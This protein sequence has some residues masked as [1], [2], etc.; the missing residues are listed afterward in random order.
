MPLKIKNIGKNAQKTRKVGQNN[1]TVQQS[2]RNSRR[3][4]RWDSDSMYLQE[5]EK[6]ALFRAIKSPRDKAIFRLAYQRGL[7]A[8]EISLLQ[9]ADYNDKRGILYVHRL[10]GSD[11][12]EYR[13]F[14]QEVTALRA[15][16]KIRGTK[17]GP[18]FPSQMGPR[19]GSRGIT[20][21]RLDQLI[22]KYAEIAGIREAKAH[23]HAL[24]HSCG[25]HL[26][27]LG[28]STHMIQNH[29]GHVNS[30]NC[31]IYLHVTPKMR[32]AAWERLKDWK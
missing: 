2:K 28:E 13:L 7:R 8:S 27:E 30:Q 24:R 25:T 31:D 17:P 29:L 20:R 18:L 9:M 22:K 6:E 4:R 14:P 32:D 16:L 12:R 1:Q 11:S 23:M 26:A 19:I 21:T 5:D 15:W 3:R 10:K